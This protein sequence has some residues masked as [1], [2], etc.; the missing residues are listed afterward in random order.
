VSD[1]AAFDFD[2]T[3]TKGG[4]VFDFL[5]ADGGRR[6]VASTMVA[7]F[8]RLDHAAVV[9]GAV[10]DHT[11]EQ[12]LERVLAGTAVE[13]VEGVAARFALDHLVRHG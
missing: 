13:Q 11:K 3:L 1:I 8:T 10:A 9:G 6:A 5:T 7:L 12:L 2:G 4:S